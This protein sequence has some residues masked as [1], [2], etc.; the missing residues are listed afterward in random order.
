[1]KKE[2]KVQFAKIHFVVHWLFIATMATMPFSASALNG[3]VYICSSLLISNIDNYQQNGT[4]GLH[5]KHNLM[6]LP[7]CVE[8]IK[9]PAICWLDTLITL[10]LL[11]SRET[12][13]AGKCSHLWY[14][15]K[16]IT[17]KCVWNREKRLR[18]SGQ[19]GHWGED[20]KRAIF[21][22]TD[23]ITL[24]TTRCRGR[25][26]HLMLLGVCLWLPRGRE[27]V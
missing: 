1:M 13:Q 4:V 7:F 8:T 23:S 5:L 26:A 27:P 3:R 20:R 16:I 19:N 18:K 9:S 25:I 12:V 15:S 6:S 11:C 24:V 22:N 2:K 10:F 21:W 17:R 14:D